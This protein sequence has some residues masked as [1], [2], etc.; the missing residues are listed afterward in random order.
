MKRSPPERQRHPTLETY[1]RVMRHGVVIDRTSG[2]ETARDVWFGV[3]LAAIDVYGFDSDAAPPPP[4]RRPRS[5][6]ERDE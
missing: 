2:E 4:L 3:S 5:K 6:L 1:E